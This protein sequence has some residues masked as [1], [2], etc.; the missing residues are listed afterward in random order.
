MRKL[1]KGSVFCVLFGLG[2]RIWGR[3]WGRG[4]RVHCLKQLA[5]AGPIEVVGLYPDRRYCEE[6]AQLL[7]RFGGR[8]TG[9]W[10]AA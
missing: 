2:C 10:R 8:V 1:E 9:F 6:I 5:V 3:S 7:E 4:A